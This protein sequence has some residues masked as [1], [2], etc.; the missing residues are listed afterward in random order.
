[1]NNETHSFVFWVDPDFASLVLSRLNREEHKVESQVARFRN[2]LGVKFLYHLFNQKAIRG[3]LS[4]TVGCLE[5][6]ISSVVRIKKKVIVSRISRIN[7]LTHIS[8]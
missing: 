6:K 4:V 1:M 5:V 7:F 8:D 2:L 3:S